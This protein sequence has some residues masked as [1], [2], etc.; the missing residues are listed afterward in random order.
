MKAKRKE[1]EYDASI[2]VEKCLRFL[3]DFAT[4]VVESKTFLEFDEE[5]LIKICQNSNLAIGETDLLNGVVR[6]GK[7]QKDSKLQDVLK[8]ILVYIRLP[9]IPEDDL[10]DIVKPLDLFSKDDIQEAI[11][12]N[13]KPEKFKDEK[14]EKFKPRAVVFVGS[15]LIS[16]KDSLQIDKWVKSKSKKP[17]KLLYK[18]TKDGFGAAQFHK[19]CDGKGETV[20][21]IKS[22]N[23]YIFGGYTP[24]SWNQTGSYEYDA[25]AFLFSLVNAQKKPL[26]FD[27]NT[28]YGQYSQLGSASYGP[29]FGGGHDFMICNNSNTTNS[30][31][32]NFGYSYTITSTGYVYGNTQAQSFLAGSYNFKT[33][34]VE[35]YG[36]QK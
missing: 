29:T 7:A 25:T 20:S 5:T 34:D 19:L 17:W 10:K 36:K 26:K 32:S 2:L 21:V 4:D 3:E 30:S 12:F 6:W 9:Q 24:R 8:K 16:P 14:D 22:T 35:V 31:Y 15:T 18:A 33:L 13:T 23:G 1:F 11:E 27:Q 28:V